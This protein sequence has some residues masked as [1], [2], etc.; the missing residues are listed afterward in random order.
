MEQRR[1]KQCHHSN[2]FGHTM[3]WDA[4]I[5]TPKPLAPAG[6]PPLAGALLLLTAKFGE[7]QLA[8]LHVTSFVAA[9]DE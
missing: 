4:M 3:F 1:N 5:T 7:Y 6:N 9:K 8:L 2:G